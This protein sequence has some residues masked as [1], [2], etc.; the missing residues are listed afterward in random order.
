MIT[1]MKEGLVL[2]DARAGAHETIKDLLYGVCS[3]CRV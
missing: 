2:D 3:F 1:A